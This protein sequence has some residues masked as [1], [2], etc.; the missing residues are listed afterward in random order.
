MNSADIQ[1]L[2]DLYQAKLRL[3]KSMEILSRQFSVITITPQNESDSGISRLQA[4]L[5]ERGRLITEIDAIDEQITANGDLGLQ[6]SVVQ[7]LR[8]E[9]LQVGERI[10]QMNLHL[11]KELERE[12]GMLRQEAHKEQSRQRSVRAYDHRAEAGE[13]FF[14]DK[15]R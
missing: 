12:T 11:E 13:G 1:E 14:I 2:V 10:H 3:F 8:K 6:L 7:G 5:E 15:R 4:L 9:I